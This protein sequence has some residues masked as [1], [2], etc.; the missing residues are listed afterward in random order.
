MDGTNLERN[1]YLT[2]QLT[3]L[4]IPVVIAINMIDQV[5]K[6]ENKIN[7][8]ALESKLGCPVLGISALKKTG[9]QEVVDACALRAANISFQKPIVSFPSLI[10]AT[11]DKIQ[12]TYLAAVPDNLK[13]W[14]A[15][16]IFERDNKILNAVPLSAADQNGYKQNVSQ[17]YN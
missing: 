10:S 3:E 12:Q 17:M 11:L 15:L 2:T 1:L 7:F 4:N 8:P 16:K 13:Y 6:N 5:G 14:Y 9:L